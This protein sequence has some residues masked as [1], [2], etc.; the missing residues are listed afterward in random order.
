M[1]SKCNKRRNMS[2]TIQNM[3]DEIIIQRYKEIKKERQRINLNRLHRKYYYK[4]LEDNR[5][6]HNEKQKE[7][8][9]NNREEISRKQKERYHMKKYGN[10]D[11]LYKKMNVLENQ[12]NI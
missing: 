3:S 11:R 6:Y 7:Y 1:F 12:E 9:K 2:E 10:L 4:N 5:I 8:Y